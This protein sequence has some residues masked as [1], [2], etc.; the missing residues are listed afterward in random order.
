MV[1]A[2]LAPLQSAGLKVMPYLDDWLVATPF[3]EQ[4][5]QDIE[6]VL[7]HVQYLSFKVNLKKSNL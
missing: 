2:T 3:Y 7:S 1:A 5:M 6:T 4:V